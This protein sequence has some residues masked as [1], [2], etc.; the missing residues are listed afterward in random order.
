MQPETII[1]NQI[2][3]YL[4]FRGIYAFP[5]KNGGTY[6]PKSKKFRR[7]GMWHKNGVS[8]ILGILNDGRF[9]AIE[10]K[11]KTGRAS[12][13]QKEFL[14]EISS[15]GGVSFIARDVTEVEHELNKHLRGPLERRLSSSE[16]Q[17]ST[18]GSPVSWPLPKDEGSC[19]RLDSHRQGGSEEE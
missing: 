3:S 2:M 16:S 18:L 9:L 14:A 5:V 19:S 1:R 6:D 11:T 15:R 7:T 10:V 17:S 13:E 8:D 4:K 12:L